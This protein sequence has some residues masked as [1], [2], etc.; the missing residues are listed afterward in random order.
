MT[1]YSLHPEGA[2]NWETSVQEIERGIIGLDPIEKDY[3]RWK[4]VLKNQEKWK[5]GRS[6]NKDI[7]YTKRWLKA[8]NLIAARAD[9]SKQIVVMKK[10]TYDK[11]LEE[12]IKKTECIKTSSKIVEAIDRRVRKLEGTKLAKVLPFIRKCR[13]PRP[14]IPRLFA[15]AKTHKE[16]KEIRP[17]VE[18]HK[19]PTFFLEK[20]LQEYISSLMESSNLVA[21]DPVM[22]VKELQ[23]ITLMDEE[24][25]TVLDYESL[26]PS[27]KINSCLETLLELLFR[28]NP[29][30]THHRNEVIEMANLICCES[31]FTF[32]GQTYK[33]N[34]GV[35]MGSPIS[36]LLCEL[37][38]RRLEEKVLKSFEREIV[39]YKK[40]VDDLFIIWRNN[41][42][43]TSFMDRI[44]DNDKGLSLKLEQKSSIMVHFLDIN[45]IFSKG[46]VSTVYIKP[47][48]SPLYIPA[49]SNDPYRYKLAAFCTL[50]R[51]A[52]LYCDNVI[53]RVTDI[54]RIIQLA[55]TLGYKRNIITGIVKFE[56]NND[57]VSRQ[58]PSKYTKF[59][60][61]KYLG[62]I[63]KEIAS[64]KDSKMA[65]AQGSLVGWEEAEVVRQVHSPTLTKTAEKMEIYRSKLKEGCINARDV[66]GLPSAW[67]FAVKKLISSASTEI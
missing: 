61:N 37:V 3:I 4:T 30:L 22:V 45:I 38:V 5:K 54:E 8:N 29:T 32:E 1:K 50:V 62:G 23:D 11:A 15:F 20:R 10:Q 27:I 56:K 64:V 40:Y 51:R 9:K 17:I 12:Y 34:R 49:K 63:M 6:I 60:F 28:E 52:F 14:G 39:Y 7:L 55:E 31:F 48:H 36:G 25:G 42:E 18:K 46:H 35:P 19:A 2:V 24:V 26:Y 67:K 53:D 16:G 59:T 57:K 21:K 65:Q 41:R 33:Q 43:I 47:T 13:N 44:N 66:E 58:G